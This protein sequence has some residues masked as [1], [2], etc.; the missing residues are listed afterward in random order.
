VARRL[1][2]LALAL[3]VTAG[4]AAGSAL[5]AGQRAEQLGD[6]DRAV[7]EY[8]RALRQNP[9]DRD[10]RLALDRARLRAADAHF[11][12]GRRLAAQNRYEEALIEFQIAN[13]L[14]PASADVEAELRR[15]RASLRAKLAVPAGGQTALEALIARS[16]A[17]PPPGLDL[18]DDILMPAAIVTG[19]RTTSRELYQML[20]K[21]ADV[22]VI[23]DPSFESAPAQVDFRGNGLRDA[24][25]AVSASTRNFWRVTAPRTITIVPDTPL[26]RREYQEDVVRTFYLSNAD[27]KETTDLLRVVVDA[28][29]VYATTATNSI[30]IRDTPERI[31]AVGRLLGA[32]DKARPEVVVDVELLEVDRERFKEYGLQIASG[33]DPGVSGGLAV[34]EDGLTLRGLRTLTQSDV[35]IFGLPALYYR[36]LKTD[37]NTRTLASPHIRMSDGIAT[38][39]RFGE[40][41]PVPV[42]TFVPIAQGGV[43]QQAITSVVYEPIGV[44]I[45]ILPR[46]HHDD[47]VTL[48]LK[49]EV[50]N[51]AG[52]GFQG[53]P[54]FGSRVVSTTIRLRDGETNILAGLIRDDERTVLHGVPGLSDLPIVGRLFG[55]NQRQTKETDIIITMT[56]HI[57]RV[58]DLTEEDLRAF[59]MARDAAAFGSMPPIDIPTGSPLMPRDP[60]PPPGGDPIVQPG[61]PLGSL[62]MVPSPIR[63]P[64][65]PKKP[66]GGGEK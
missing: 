26:K 23:F 60:L 55:R 36:L 1:V 43:N 46:L 64:A 40:R 32:I 13:E 4:C 52:A 34:N 20:A 48:N 44:N 33:G 42:T 6:Y 62:P 51:V 2:L 50:S 21:F 27:L 53:L 56:P 29:Q 58:L 39:A 31:E 65:P 22:N 45:D 8:T 16:R 38:Q 61:V 37:T 12:R 24:L 28:R 3:A 15:T 41:V 35:I 59:R 49:V 57:V 66:G 17:Q 11:S 63:P 30:T 19:P 9:G 25:D 18:P 5:R 14:N 54:T 7:A 47:Q 10:A